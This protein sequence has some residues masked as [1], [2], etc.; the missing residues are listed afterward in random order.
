MPLS[1]KGNEIEKAMEKTYG[2]TK[3]EQVFYASKNAGKITG[4]DSPK[5]VCS[6]FEEIARQNENK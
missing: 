3:G 6:N 1:E 2:A 4:V 5:G